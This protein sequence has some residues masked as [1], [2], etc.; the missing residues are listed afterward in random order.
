MRGRKRS[1]Q[2]KQPVKR[3]LD[4]LSTKKSTKSKVVVRKL[5]D[6][7]YETA[8]DHSHK[9][10]VTSSSSILK[11]YEEVRNVKGASPDPSLL[12]QQT[13]IGE[14]AQPSETVRQFLM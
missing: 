9:E 1:S 4:G 14:Q 2:G 5:V 6:D 11:Q 12:S 7:D 3:L 13:A 10:V 8:S